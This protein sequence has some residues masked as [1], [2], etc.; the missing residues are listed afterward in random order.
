MHFVVLRFSAMGDVALTLPVIQGA[1]K[2]HPEISITIVT[3]KFFSPFFENIDRLKIITADFSGRHKGFPGLIR[4][5]K[6]IMQIG[7]ITGVIDLHSVLRTHI[8]SSLFK[9]K[10]IKTYRIIKDRQQKEQHLKL[11]AAPN[12]MHTIQR[13]QEVFEAFGLRATINH[14]PFFRLS[15]ESKAM[16][17]KFIENKGLMKMNLIGIAPFAK[18]K[19]KIWPIKKVRNFIDAASKLENTHI[20]LFGGGKEESEQLQL[21]AGRY[22]HCSTVHLD[23][24][25]E[26]ALISRMEC[27]ISMDSANMHIAALSGIPVVSVWGATHPGMGFS[28][29]AQPD[30]NSIQ[31]TVEELPCRPCTIYG[32]GFCRRNDFACM[33]R[34][35]FDQVLK[36]VKPLINN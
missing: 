20:L 18:H 7:E 33:E 27:M 28:A 35:N 26:L 10:K 23:L 4:L 16:A 21:L 29:W 25:A 9:A 5:F 6:E 11:K 32:K 30:E 17:E 8:L 14:A 1:L 36:V 12:L 22:E 2:D 19:L 15:G 34:I 24:A 13:Y 31:V 3:R